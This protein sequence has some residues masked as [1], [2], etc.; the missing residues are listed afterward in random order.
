MNILFNEEDKK[1]WIDWQKRSDK[2]RGVA[3]VVVMP[4]III[5]MVLY[6]LALVDYTG[7]PI[8]THLSLL[9]YMTE[10]YIVSIITYEMMA[11]A[12]LFHLISRITKKEPLVVKKAIV[13]IDPNNDYITLSI[14]YPNTKTVL[15]TQTLSVATFIKEICNVDTNQLN[16][17]GV[18]YDIGVNNRNHVY[19][20]SE[21]TYK[22]LPET[23]PSDINQV[24]DI[25]KVIKV[26]YKH[27]NI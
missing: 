4:I 27:L 15:Y 20:S 22:L 13:E 21:R 12:F 25:V 17:N 9:W 1:A 3:M 16:V 5:T 7:S 23:K 8:D 24:K 19:G 2:F 26:L 14:I 10:K 6:V 18:L 11:G